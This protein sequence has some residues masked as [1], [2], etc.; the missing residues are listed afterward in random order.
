[1]RFNPPDSWFHERAR[2]NHYVYGFAHMMMKLTRMNI[3]GKALEIGSFSGESTALIGMFGLFDEIHCVEPFD[4]EPPLNTEWWK[5]QSEFSL[6]TRHYPVTLH[7][8]YSYD[9]L[10]TLTD[11]FNF[12][13]IDAAHDYDSVK[14][15]IELALPLL[16]KGGVIAGHDYNTKTFPGVVQA[17]HDTLGTPTQQFADESWMIA[18]GK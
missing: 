11:K 7:Q 5:V 3:N 17:V 13:Y 10:P 18:T 14:Q 9:V 16:E 2:Y 8:G 1:M 4:G 15:D 12:I 6:N